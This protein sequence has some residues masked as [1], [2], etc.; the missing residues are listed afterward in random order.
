MGG[1][2]DRVR[3]PSEFAELACAAVLLAIA[4]VFFVSLAPR[5]W[6]GTPH[7]WLAR[8]D[9]YCE[10]PRAEWIRQPANTWSCLAGRWHVITALS[11]GAVYL[12]LRS[13]ER[14]LAAA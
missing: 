8:A 12:Y 11:P 3:L 2:I 6:P 7:A 13:G 1:P 4:A 10:A 9:W 14:A 5:G